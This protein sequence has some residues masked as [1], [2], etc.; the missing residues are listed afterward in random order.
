MGE[1]TTIRQLLE[2]PPPAPGVVAAARARLDRATLGPGTSRRHPLRPAWVFA[3]AGL[4]VA[5]AA[6][7]IAVQVV[8]PGGAR[9]ASALTVRELADRAAAAATRQPVVRPGQWV[10]WKERITG[11]GCVSGCGSSFHVWT[12]AD[13]GRAAWVY[14]GRIVYYI[15]KGPFIGQPQPFSGPHGPGYGWSAAT[16]PMP[17]SYAK[18]GSLPRGARALGRYLAN[19][20]FPYSRRWGPRAI[21]E[22]AVIETLLTSYVM[23]PRLS[24]EM[25]RALGYIPG[26][27]V[28]D[29]AVDV[30]GRRGVGLVSMALPNVGRVEIVLNPRTYRLMG[31][32]L[33]G[34][35]DYL[36]SGTAILRSALVSGPGV[37]P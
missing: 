18:L 25:Y 11:N 6:G 9:P 12:T 33:W 14:K 17:I 4:A 27:T 29:H 13:S 28:T 24:A 1:L 22:F 30:A 8:A 35:H 20:T 23:P 21:R 2:E 16:G 7:L 19:V 34:S 3:V 10:F 26:V 32:N 37:W 15:G 31:V 36:I 5:A